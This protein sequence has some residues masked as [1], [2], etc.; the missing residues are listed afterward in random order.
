MRDELEHIARIDRYISGEM[1][2]E[3]AESFEQEIEGNDALKE[4][5]DFYDKIREGISRQVIKLD[6]KK[7]QYRFVKARKKAVRLRRLIYG[8]GS[9]L[10]MV[11]AVLVTTLPGEESEEKFIHQIFDKEDTEVEEDSFKQYLPESEFFEVPPDKDTTITSSD[12]LKVHIPKGAFIRP[13]GKRVKDP[14][15]IELAADQGMDDL[16]LGN[17]GVDNSA[18]PL[19]S[20][21]VLYFNATENGQAL[22]INDALPPYIEVPT[23]SVK[24]GM[25]VYNG[26]RS[27]TGEMDWYAPRLPD[28]FLK[29]VAFKYLDFL[30]KGFEKKVQAGL[31]YKN[32]STTSRELLDS[33]FYSLA[34]GA[35]FGP[36]LGSSKF[37]L[38]KSPNAS[39]QML[40]SEADA[41]NNEAARR[42]LAEAE[43]DA[44]FEPM[45][46]TEAPAVTFDNILTSSTGPCGVAP[47]LIQTIR[48][49]KFERSLL[50]T[51]EFEE[52]L[53]AIYKTCDEKVLNL[54]VEHTEKNLW[55]LDAM[56]ADYLGKKEQAS[57]FRN[58]SRQK[59]TNVPNSHIY[60][61]LIAKDFEK[62]LKAFEKEHSKKRKTYEKALQK[63]TK[64]AEKKIEQLAKEYYKV[65]TKRVKTRMK[66]YGFKVKTMGWK[67]IARVIEGPSYT[68]PPLKVSIA[69]NVKFDHQHA[70]FSVPGLNVIGQLNR[71]NANQF[72]MN[73]H[74]IM[75]LPRHNADEIQLIGIGYI[76][77]DIYLKVIT[78]PADQSGEISL[79]LEKTEEGKARQILKSLSGKSKAHSLITALDYQKEFYKDQ[80][81]RK[82]LRKEAALIVALNRLAFPCCQNSHEYIDTAVDFEAPELES[83][84]NAL[85]TE[86][87]TTSSKLK[88]KKGIEVILPNGKK[89]YITEEDEPA[90]YKKY[91]EMFKNGETELKK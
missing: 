45:D 38:G 74:R 6:I 10:L 30:P 88:T 57:V 33:L 65:T 18:D 16:V 60:S 47:Q 39:E 12:G 23:D 62:D 69:Q 11:V 29:P 7:A 54:Y 31:P 44:Q 36:G 70:Y 3:E 50:A 61:A 2:N 85:W 78:H 27:K 59:L 8:G 26:K 89:K 90:L 1:S 41:R 87:E 40:I 64:K 58:F 81:R 35:E 72:M 17:L 66:A 14:I 68:P 20:A 24:P 91:Y 4:E 43:P 37:R 19:E 15:N 82:K 34:T 84:D 22:A 77:K 83:G 5:V 21:Q 55:E 49:D 75:N 56:A 28:N 79:T 42:L 25:Q 13:N 63:S 73:E 67:N 52:R 46:S 86:Y 53:P 80:Q 9:L 32:H 71:V 76:G 51:R 48:Q